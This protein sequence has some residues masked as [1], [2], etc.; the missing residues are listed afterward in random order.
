M[1]IVGICR[2]C[3]I[4]GDISIGRFCRAGHL[5]RLAK[6]FGLFH[7][8]LGPNA[9]IQIGSF[10]FKEIIGNHA[11]LGTGTT[12]EEQNGI[13]VRDI[14]QFLEQG[15]CFVHHGLKIFG[16]MAD[17]HN[18]KARSVKIQY[19]FCCFFDDFTRKNRRS[20]TEIMLFHCKNSFGYTMRY[21]C[22]STWRIYGFNSINQTFP[23]IFSPFRGKCFPIYCI[24]PHIPTILLCRDS[25]FH[26]K[27]LSK[28]KSKNH[29]Y[30]IHPLYSLQNES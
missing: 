25:K 7:C 21:L 27:N 22:L 6:A 29:Y 23:F 12:T 8:L 9:C 26:L 20:C 16:T 2:N 13:T 14:Q 30:S 24:S 5:Y 18:G 4:F 11:E 17:F 1:E 19:T 15:N 10:L 3:I 28:C